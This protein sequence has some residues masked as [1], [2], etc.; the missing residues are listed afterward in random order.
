MRVLLALVVMTGGQAEAQ[1]RL[2]CADLHRLVAAARAPAPFAEF[3]RGPEA[4][5]PFLGLGAA[6][7]RGR[8]G[9]DTLYCALHRRGGLTRPQIF[10]Q[11]IACLPGAR[12]GVPPAVPRWRTPYHE[13]LDLLLYGDVWVLLGD[14]DPQTRL[15]YQVQLSLGRGEPPGD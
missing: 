11:A 12:R 13:G 1:A 5:W 6:C 2:D 15:G 4:R 9:D 8:S 10:E 7:S 14:T 3:P